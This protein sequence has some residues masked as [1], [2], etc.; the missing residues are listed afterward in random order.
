MAEGAAVM[1]IALTVAFTVVLSALVTAST[2]VLFRLR[3]L[4]V[5]CLRVAC[6]AA[7]VFVALVVAEIWMMILQ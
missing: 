3:S 5:W 7:I 1:N 2:A 6:I 4:W